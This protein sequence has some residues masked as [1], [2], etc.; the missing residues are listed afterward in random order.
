MTAGDFLARLVALI[1]AAGISHMVAGSFASTFH[2]IARATQD[3]DLV[4]DPT[5]AA[6]DAF[7]RRWIH[8]CITSFPTPPAMPG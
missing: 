2:G 3:L 8:M 5:G 4:I 7:S 6:L 1:E